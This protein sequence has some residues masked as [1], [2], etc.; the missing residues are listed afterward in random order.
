M[1]L[2]NG[3]KVPLYNRWK[4]NNWVESEAG[5][6]CAIAVDL[7][8]KVAQLPFQSTSTAKIAESYL[9][10]AGENI[11][12]CACK[13]EADWAC[14]T[15]PLWKG[16]SAVIS[17][18]KYIV[19]PKW[20]LWTEK[21]TFQLKETFLKYTQSLGSWLGHYLLYVGGVYLIW[22]AAQARIYLPPRRG[23]RIRPERAGSLAWWRL[24]S[25][26]SRSHPR[27]FAR[28]G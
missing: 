4:K 24:R 10:T 21:V 14:T 3:W 16:S 22:S 13:S 7:C 20:Q 28:P 2:N 26:P 11:C 5:W 18:Y 27:F 12:S 25:P 23:C 6:A 8:E 9:F 17:D 19:Q 1:F 15:R